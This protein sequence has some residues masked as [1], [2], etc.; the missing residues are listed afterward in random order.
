MIKKLQRQL[1]YR[2]P[3]VSYMVV[4]I[5]VALAWGLRGVHGHERGGAIA[6][7]MAGL[8]LA[9]V[10]GNP[11]WLIASVLGS[12]G[13]AVGGALSYGMFV[14][15]AFEGVLHGVFA[16][17]LVGIAWG[18]IGGLALGL[19]YALPQ[20]RLSERLSIGVGLFLVWLCVDFLLPSRMTGLQDLA[21]RDLLVL[22]LV[23][24]WLLLTAYVGAW[25]QDRRS[26]FLA[27]GCAL[28][29]GIGFPAAAW[30]QGMGQLTIIPI[31]WW[32]IAE[33][34]IGAVGGLALAIFALKLEAEWVPP[35]EFHPWER[36]ALCAWLLWGI[37][38]WALANNLNHWVVERQTMDLQSAQSVFGWAWVALGVFVLF[39]WLEIKRGRAFVVS[40]FPHQLRT[41][42]LA[43][44]WLVT[45]IAIVKDIYP[46]GF[47]AWTPTQ[48][49]F[50]LMA[51]AVTAL[52]PKPAHEWKPPKPT[53]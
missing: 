15:M 38:F 52:L 35:F 42:F 43:F 41:V 33:H 6:G 21:V 27:V 3:Y 11:R 20:Y 25:K 53:E 10:T 34:S 5:A 51:A 12:L 45:A 28:G 22:V 18:G 14:Q 46:V 37:P 23:G 29:F 2:F 8:A 7:G 31:D 16:L 40:L 50:L 44:V 24:A 19:G 49:T 17:A 30:M 32:K 4:A 47:S 48:T 1:T 39:G 9:A 13:F 26:L 36:W